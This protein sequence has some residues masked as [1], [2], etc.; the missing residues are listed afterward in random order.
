[1][2]K[3][4]NGLGSADR[5]FTLFEGF[6]LNRVNSLCPADRKFTLFEGF[7]PN[8]VNGLGSADRKFTLFEGFL[9]NR[10]NFLLLAK[11]FLLMSI[12]ITILPSRSLVHISRIELSN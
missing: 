5:K 4:V 7:L 3:R 12:S 9:L 8:R 11:L 10:V 6:L 2:L 1:M